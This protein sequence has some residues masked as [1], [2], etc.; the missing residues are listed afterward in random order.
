MRSHFD[1][2]QVA[3]GIFAQIEITKMHNHRIADV[4]FD[5]R[6][7]YG[8][9]RAGI[10]GIRLVDVPGIDFAVVRYSPVFRVAAQNEGMCNAP[11][12]FSTRGLNIRRV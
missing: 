9:H 7:R 8:S 1:G 11:P 10:G 2:Q 12:S 5:H 3:A 6:A 4:T